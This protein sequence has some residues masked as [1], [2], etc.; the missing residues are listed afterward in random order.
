MTRRDFSK[1][2]FAVLISALAANVASMV[3]SWIFP[4]GIP[5]EWAIYLPLIAFYVVL[6]PV[7]LLVFTVL[8]PIKADGG[9]LVSE[10]KPKLKMT[11][12]LL[13]GIFCFCMAC[14]YLGNVV[15]IGFT[16]ALSTLVF[17]KT[18]S[19]LN[20]MTNI[21]S[22]N[23]LLAFLVVAV[24]APIC[25]EFVFR[26]L[27]LDRLRPA[28]ELPAILCCGL[29]FGMYHLNFTQFFYAAILGF[30]F[31]YITLKTG[32]ILWSTILHIMINTMGS[33]VMSYLASG[34]NLENPTDPKT[35]LFS[36]AILGIVGLLFVGGIIFLALTLSR[37]GIKIE[38]SAETDPAKKATFSKAFLNVGV[39]IYTVV[40]LAMF[41]VMLAA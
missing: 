15:G 24:L 23:Y 13:I 7:A 17:G 9:A 20:P 12:I 39:I 37:K 5:G 8:S 10:Q 34:M 33:V 14:S 1:L 35:I 6:V 22:T 21:M 18:T 27:L 28:G 26:K 25:E 3:P 16:Y 41:A 29:A 2:G 4:E 38:K 30:I 19:I 32:T 36:F 11:F 40:C 31:S